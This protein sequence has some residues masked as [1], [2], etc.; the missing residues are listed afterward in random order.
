MTM[1]NREGEKYG[2]VGTDVEGR[3]SIRKRVC[4]EECL[5][6]CLTLTAESQP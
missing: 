1:E 3:R 6:K 2:A 5:I 4:E